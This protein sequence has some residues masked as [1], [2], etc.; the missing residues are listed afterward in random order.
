MIEFEKKLLR[1]EKDVYNKVYLVVKEAVD[2]AKVD[3]DIV[4]Q[5][6]CAEYFQ[7]SVNTLKDWVLRGCPEIRLDSGM[8]L[9]SKK[10]IREWLLMY[11]K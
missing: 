3:R 5:K 2:T 10:A 9:Y 1:E 7:I 11:Q 8:V 6:Y 4:K